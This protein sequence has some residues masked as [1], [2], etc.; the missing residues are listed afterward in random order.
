MSVPDL[1]VH[2]AKTEDSRLLEDVAARFLRESYSVRRKPDAS[3]TS[4][5]LWSSFA[6]M[7]WLALPIDPA[8]G[9]LGADTTMLAALM[10]Q[11]GRAALREPFIPTVI[12]GAGLLGRFTSPAAAAILPDVASGACRLAVVT[13]PLFTAEHTPGGWVLHGAAPLVLGADTADLLLIPAHCADG[14]TVLLACPLAVPGLLIQPADTISEHGAA[15][16]ACTHVRL[17]PAAFIAAKGVTEALDWM[18]DRTAALLCADAL[19][20]IGALVEATIAHTVTRMQFGRKLSAF[21]VV[22]HTIADMLIRAEEARAACQLALTAIDAP[23]P[24]RLRGVSAAKLKLGTAARKI[25]EDA[26]Q[27]HGAMGLTDELDIGVYVKRLLAFESLCGT[28]DDHAARYLIH[29]RA[30]GWAGRYLA[31]PAAPG[32]A[33][34][35]PNLVLSAA[36]EAF[37][38]RVTAFL[39]AHLSPSDAR[40]QRFTTTV[41]PEAQD[42]SAWHTTLHAQGWSAPNWPARF[43][44]TGWTPVE[45]YIWAQESGI[46]HAPIISPIG[47]PLVGPVLFAF[48]TPDQQ[49]RYLPDI[50]SGATLW[51]QGFSEPGAGSD[52]AAL[53]TRAVRDGDIYRVTGSKI[54]TTHGHTADFMAALVR[55][56][57]PGGRRDG[58]SFL[59]IDMRSPGID[60]RPI[61]T[62]GGDHEVNQIFFDDVVVPAANLVGEEGQG[63]A[64]GKFLL[65]YERG[66][67]I[68][69]AGQRALLRDIEQAAT[70]RG[71][72]SPGFWRS[73]T[74]VA[75]D[76]DTLEML[77]L[78]ML[79]APGD[80]SP[81][82]A[83]ILKLRAS[84]SQ[85]AITALGLRALG[86]DLL[87]WPRQRP[88]HH[89]N[90][91]SPSDAFAARYLNSRANTIFGGAREIQKTIIFRSV[92]RT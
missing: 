79:L 82:A 74:E 21:Q 32:E 43:G 78:R 33:V 10:E 47:L 90:E 67:D 62:I 12:M 15:D 37:R 1:S 31:R 64:I 6:E 25:A 77:E 75:A 42:A 46:R 13:A 76:L 23:V 3:D 2:L 29:A 52:L 60:I 89:H 14:T 34:A 80:C 81:A 85:Q 9:G 19:G 71:V 87:R 18:L 40:A 36:D 35:L 65:D 57:P 56:G 63:W 70:Q 50:L 92:V 58:I 7:G 49:R 16:I 68:M 44:G 61:V 72:A 48:G 83:S 11:F 24:V 91:A 54:W 55:T 38:D 84:E 66:G 86:A 88:L 8:Q 39:D 20:A 26:I 59:L 17:D 69:S 22:E 73:F 30:H 4:A 27:L 28:S 51:C 53:A 5:A 45:R 41:Y